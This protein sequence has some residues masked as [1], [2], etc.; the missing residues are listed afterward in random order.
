MKD[1]AKN[2]QMA[3][4]YRQHVLKEPQPEGGFVPLGAVGGIA[5]AAPK[6][7]EKNEEVGSFGD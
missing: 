4:L 1:A 5:P 6:K 3:K 2:A 7:A